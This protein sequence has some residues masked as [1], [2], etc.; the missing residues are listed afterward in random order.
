MISQELL[1]LQNLWKLYKG[2]SYYFNKNSNNSKTFNNF[3]NFNNKIFSNNRHKQLYSPKMPILKCHNN[4]NL[5]HNQCRTSRNSNSKFMETLWDKI[6]CR[7]I[8]KSII[9]ILISN[10]N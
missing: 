2:I 3:S 1:H 6:K 5:T 10:L 7:L 8:T 4:N 9:S